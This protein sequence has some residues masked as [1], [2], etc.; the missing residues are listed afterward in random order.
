ML[1]I[2]ES[3]G[4]AYYD[5]EDG[6]GSMAK[7]LKGARKYNDEVTIDDVRN[8]FAKH[9]GT[10]RQLKGYNSFVANRAWEYYQIDI[11]SLKI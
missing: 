7:T 2:E 4:K 1:T 3:I 10:K 8:W 5:E 6:I 11:F 9:I